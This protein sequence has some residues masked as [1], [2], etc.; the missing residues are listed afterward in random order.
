MHTPNPYG[1]GDDPRQG[2]E[3]AQ[4]LGLEP[5]PE[6][7]GLFRRTHIDAYSSAIYFMLLDPDFSALHRLQSTEVYHW[8][9]GAPLRLLLLHPDGRAEERLLGPDVARGQLPQIAVPPGVWQGSSSAGTWSLCGTT[10][11]PPFG[12]QGFELG[13]REELRLRYPEQ[14][15]RIRELSRD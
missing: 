9:A 14:A 13:D 3:L 2:R 4:A 10:M 7:G 5:L 15:S 12:W 1:P 6:E 11:A 8:Y